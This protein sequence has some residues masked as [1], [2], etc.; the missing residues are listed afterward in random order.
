[1]VNIKEMYCEMKPIPDARASEHVP[2]NSSEKFTN[3][4]GHINYPVRVRN[5]RSQQLNFDYS[6]S[7]GGVKSISAG[8]WVSP[9]TLELVT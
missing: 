2:L 4:V 8:L 5:D 6:V 9:N 3:L 1:M 7:I